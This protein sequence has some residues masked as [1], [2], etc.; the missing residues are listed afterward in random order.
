MARGQRKKSDIK[1]RRWQLPLNELP[2]L[3][4]LRPLSTV[5]SLPVIPKSDATISFKKHFEKNKKN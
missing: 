2:Y 5:R 3:D 1:H 4:A